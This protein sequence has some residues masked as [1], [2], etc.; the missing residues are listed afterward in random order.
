MKFGISFTLRIT[1]LGTLILG[2]CGQ[3]TQPSPVA[4]AATTSSEMPLHQY[5]ECIPP[6]TD[7]AIPAGSGEIERQSQ[8]QIPPRGWES[9]SAIPNPS[10]HLAVSNFTAS[11][12]SIWVLYRNNESKDVMARYSASTNEWKYYATPKNS[13]GVPTDFIVASKTGELWGYY[14]FF[15]TEGLEDG[16]SL[17]VRYNV[18]KD[19]FESVIDKQGLLQTPRTISSKIVVD[20]NGRFWMFVKDGLNDSSPTL[21]SFDPVTLQ[22]EKHNVYSE[23]FSPFIRRDGKLWIPD[24]PAGKLALY[25][26]TTRQVQYFDSIKTFTLSK[27]ETH[28]K[29]TEVIEGAG[30]LYLDRSERLWFGYTGWLDLKISEDIGWYKI[31]TPPE[32]VIYTESPLPM[33]VLSPTTLRGMHQ[34]SNGWMWFSTTDGV[35]RLKMLDSFQHGEWCKVTNGVSNVVE[36]QQG[37]LW[38]IVFSKIYKYHIKP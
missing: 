37:N 33:Y 20:E 22:A 9:I 14:S 29:F 18:I 4:L 3:T 16:L 24:W 30:P 27:G 32:F 19:Q 35:V 2:A 12:N 25:D 8:T 26:P 10:E 23:T 11:G 15:S 13:Y 21:Y 28:V 7:L 5:D 31:I 36:D 6:F 38:M 34:S 17:L 1:A